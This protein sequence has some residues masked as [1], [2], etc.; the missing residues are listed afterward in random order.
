[1][2][3]RLARMI[4]AAAVV[5][6]AAV[7]VS[8]CGGAKDSDRYAEA[9][10]SAGL[11]DAV[12]YESFSAGL[13]DNEVRARVDLSKVDGDEQEKLLSLMEEQRLF[14][15]DIVYPNG[16][17][18]QLSHKKLLRPAFSLTEL[19]EELPG[20]DVWASGHAL[21][22]GGTIN[23]A[24][25]RKAQPAAGQFDI[26]VLV[27]EEDKEITVRDKLAE[28]ARV[29]GLWKAAA[30]SVVDFTSVQWDGGVTS[31]EALVDTTGTLPPGF[32]EQ[33]RWVGPY[34]DPAG[35]PWV[36]VRGSDGK[37]IE[38]NMPLI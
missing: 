28:P 3:K 4:S 19:D 5:C 1:M 31:M 33:L 21:C 38:T 14:F 37:V 18:G 25:L 32:R 13:P 2:K 16:R 30:G 15:I 22:L 9:A 17:E 23:E 7:G 26:T 24:I 8:A 20:T 34:L 11:G 36:Q 10:Q 27:Y 35:T 6:A 29:A 12:S